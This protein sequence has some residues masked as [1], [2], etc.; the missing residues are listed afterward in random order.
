MSGYKLLEQFKQ[1]NVFILLTTIILSG[2]FL[3]FINFYTIKILNANRAYVNGESHYSKGQ[4]DATRFIITFIYTGNPRQWELFKKELSVPQGDGIARIGLMHNGS[5]ENIKKGFRDGRN[6]ESDL[7][8]MI[9]LF[10]NFYQFFFLKNAVDEWVKA[11]PLIDQLAVIGEEIHARMRQH[12]FSEAE[13]LTYLGRISDIADQL[14]IHQNNFSSELGKSSRI[15]KRYLF[16][17]NI[18]FIL[19]IIG[20]VSFYYTM[21]VKKLL[22]AKQQTDENNANL[23]KTNKELDHFVHSASHDLRSPITS[24]KGMIQVIKLESDRDKINQY[25]DLMDNSL[26]KQ[27]QFISDIIDYSKNKRKELV[28]EAVNLSKMTDGILDQLHYTIDAGTI[29][30]RKQLEIDTVYTDSL[31]LKIVLN[32]LLSNAVKYSDENKDNKYILIKSHVSQGFCVIAVEDN[33]IGIKEENLNRIFEMFFV[34]NAN[35][36]SGLGLYIVKEAVE[37]LKGTIS[38]VSEINKGST[39]TIKIPQHYGN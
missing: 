31:R 33:G 38:V 7:D 17:T 39:F 29:D 37:N 6:M 23:S 14:T 16:Y 27:D 21:M 5:V 18:F 3:I 9:W 20:S 12:S 15:V 34:A 25:L 32:N 22:H 24:L 28:I 35:K 26:M 36:G 1:P 13:R 30:I 19:T 2:T 11:D 10:R 4:K 8:D